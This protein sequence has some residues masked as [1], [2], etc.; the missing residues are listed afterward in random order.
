MKLQP[1]LARDPVPTAI[2]PGEYLHSDR[3]LFFV[4]ECADD[5]ALIED[6][7][8][9]TLIQVERDWLNGL[10]EVHRQSALPEPVP[11]MANDLGGATR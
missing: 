1:G 11:P 5:W 3:D 7:H 8:S 2:R 4:V 9:N 10:H 6:C